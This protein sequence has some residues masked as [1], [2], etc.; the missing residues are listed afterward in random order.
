LKQLEREIKSKVETPNTFFKKKIV[1]DL[2]VKLTIGGKVDG[3]ASIFSRKT[4]SGREKVL[5][6][7]KNRQNR[8]FDKV[9]LYENIQVQIYLWILN[10]DKCYFIQRFNGKNKKT[11]ISRDQLFI[12]EIVL[13]CKDVAE[14]ICMSNLKDTDDSNSS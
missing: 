8:F 3:I 7:I 11:K 10:L 2:G 14:K 13:K 12:D 9:P 1:T 4:E 6:E 5:V